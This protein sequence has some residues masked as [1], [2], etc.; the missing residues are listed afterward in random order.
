[1]NSSCLDDISKLVR[2]LDDLDRKLDDLGL[3]EM[4]FG[5]DLRSRPLIERPKILAKLLMKAPENTKFSEEL[6]GARE[7]LL[8]VAPLQIT[9]RIYLQFPG[10]NLFSSL[11]F[12]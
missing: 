3:K 6:Q 4:E 12:R 8:Q 9:N 2:K 11:F 10:D 5:T 7:E 1:M